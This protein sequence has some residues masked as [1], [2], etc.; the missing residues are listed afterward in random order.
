MRNVTRLT[1][2]V[3]AGGLWAAGGA[4]PACADPVRVSVNI[5][6]QRETAPFVI[7]S[8]GPF[9]SLNSELFVQLQGLDNGPLAPHQSVWRTPMPCIGRANCVPGQRV[10]FSNEL[11]LHVPVIAY[12]II[13]GVERP[14]WEKQLALEGNLRLIMDELAL[15]L[16]ASVVDDFNGPLFN[17]FAP[18]RFSGDLTITGP[19]FGQVSFEVFGR[20]IANATGLIN[21]IRPLDGRPWVPRP[22]VALVDTVRFNP[23][24]VPEPASFVLVGTGAVALVR[25]A[26]NRRRRI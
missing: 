23:A 22:G 20:G 16:T 6:T 14:W 12:S 11:S 9:F 5:E 18:Y 24:P 8:S 2:V 15:P 17:A 19:E 7:L 25:F 1:F 26:R 13:D 4:A 3:L 21:A 10:N